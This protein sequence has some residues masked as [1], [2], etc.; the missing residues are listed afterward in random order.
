MPASMR[1]AAS[2]AEDT[3]G[4]PRLEMV[5][6][7]VLLGLMAEQYER[8]KS[9]LDSLEESMSMPGAQVDV[10]AVVAS[11]REVRQA[12]ESLAKLSF[13]VQDRPNITTPLPN[14]A[15]DEAITAALE[16]RGVRVH[17]NNGEGNNG[18]SPTYDSERDG[19]RAIT[20]T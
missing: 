15:I 18:D 13:S 16:R 8:S 4:S 17:S 14:S 5:T 12:I 3:S 11:L 2:R 10:R 6:G 20:A 9:M 7:D 19:I 1:A